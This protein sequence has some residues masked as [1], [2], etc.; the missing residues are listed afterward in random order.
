M[1]PMLMMMMM[2]QLMKQS[3]Q[4][5]NPMTGLLMASLMKKMSSASS[6]DSDYDYD[7]DE[8]DSDYDYDNYS[9]ESDYDYDYDNDSVGSDYDYDYETQGDS[10]PNP[11]ASIIQQMMQQKL[12][13]LKTPLVQVTMEPTKA[14]EMRPTETPMKM[15]VEISKPNV[16]IAQRPM[17]P[18]D[19]EIGPSEQVS[20]RS[21]P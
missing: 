21:A 17:E 7:Y 9:Y 6:D 16:E 18:T 3:S 4:Q 13:A 19:K 14:A 1:N 10:A 11:L 2:P 15:S 20:Y 8:S 12:G 5:K